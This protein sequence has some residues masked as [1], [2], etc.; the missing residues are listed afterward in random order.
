[1]TL[2][3]SQWPKRLT[4]SSIYY[5]LVDPECDHSD[6]YCWVGGNTSIRTKRVFDLLE[7]RE[8]ID[9]RDGGFQLTQKGWRVLNKLKGT[10]VKVSEWGSSG[11]P[12]FNSIWINSYS[13]RPEYN[14]FYSRYD[15]Q[16]G[17]KQ[18]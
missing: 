16:T 18:D 5:W 6:C 14:A 3:A 12:K 2:M 15:V 17:A 9:K 13:Q 8:M 7:K 11:Y 4:I 1:M 10:P